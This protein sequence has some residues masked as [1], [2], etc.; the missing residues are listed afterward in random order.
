VSFIHV[1]RESIHPFIH[2]ATV[3]HRANPRASSSRHRAH[4]AEDIL[5]VV[6]VVVVV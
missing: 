1:I 5:V 3:L 6:V 2:R 4:L